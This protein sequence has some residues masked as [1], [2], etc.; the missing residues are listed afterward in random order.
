[1][2]TIREQEQP[3]TTPPK[4]KDDQPARYVSRRLTS[5][6]QKGIDVVLGGQWGDEGKG[7]LVDILSQVC[8][9][10]LCYTPS[11]YQDLPSTFYLTLYAYPT[12]QTLYPLIHHTI[13]KM[14]PPSTGI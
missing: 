3:S 6:N 5:Q 8:I 9:T 1:M 14:T 13:N 12:F 7:K 11:S 10:L 4:Q 2:G